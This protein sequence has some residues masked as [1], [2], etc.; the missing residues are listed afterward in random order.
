MNSPSPDG[1][2]KR[3]EPSGSALRGFAPLG[4][5]TAGL[6]AVGT[7]LII[8][9]MLLVNAD[10]IGRNLLKAPV[11]GVVELTEA[12]IVIIVFLQVGHTLRA[13]RFTRSDGLFSALEKGRPRIASGLDALY[14][15]TGAGLFGLLAVNAFGRFSEAWEGGYYA[16]ILGAFTMPT[17]PIELTIT[18]GSVVMTLQFLAIFWFRL[19]I[20]TGYR[21]LGSDGAQ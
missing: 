3:A 12:A 16:G 9:L 6:N 14:S 17:W 4:A 1:D 8:A 10:V 7:V 19:Q 13:G 15:L 5:I 11:P 21:S 2:N 20:V 18:I